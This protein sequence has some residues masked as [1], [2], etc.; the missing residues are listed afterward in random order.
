MLC[1]RTCLVSLN[2]RQHVAVVMRRQAVYRP[3]ADLQTM[4]ER[5]VIRTYRLDTYSILDLCQQLKAELL[6]AN[7]NQHAIPPL[8]KVLSVLH[9]LS[10]GSFQNTVGLYGGMSQ[11]MFSGVLGDVLAALLPHLSTYIKFARQ[12]DLAD[13]KAECSKVEISSGQ[14]V[15]LGRAI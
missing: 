11:P 15:R 3:F 14:V 6:P 7:R 10:M 12:Q 9:F 2:H 1:D 4:D 8:V 5:D 13:V